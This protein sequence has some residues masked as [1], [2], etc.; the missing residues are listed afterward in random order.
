VTFPIDPSIMSPTR[1][2]APSSM[3]SSPSTNLSGQGLGTD[4]AAQK[5]FSR[6][7]PGLKYLFKLLYTIK[8]AGGPPRPR[9]NS[10]LA[11]K[12][13]LSRLVGRSRVGLFQPEITWLFSLP[14]ARCSPSPMVITFASSVPRPSLA[15]VTP[16]CSA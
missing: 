2:P 9:L 15:S 13:G 16:D 11:R 8:Y 7:E 1:G 14:L 4:L 5:N 10:S 3:D 12:T 6:L